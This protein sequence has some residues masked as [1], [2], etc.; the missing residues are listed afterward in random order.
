MNTTSINSKTICKLTTSVIVL[1]FITCK[2]SA[3]LAEPKITFISATTDEDP[4]GKMLHK[5]ISA[6]AKSLNIELNIIQSKA[7]QHTTPEYLS[8]LLDAKPDYLIAASTRLNNH[9][10]T[11]SK[12]KEIYI[13]SSYPPS[14]EHENTLGLPRLQHKH[15]IG[16]IDYN[17]KEASSQLT[18]VMYS[19]YSKQHLAF[20]TQP[21][22]LAFNG[23]K[24]TI[25]AIDRREGLISSANDLNIKINHI[26][27][28]D[29]QPNSSTRSLDLSLKRYPDTSI[30]WAASDAISL[31]IIK[32]LKT[33][34][35]KPNIDF[36]TAGFDWTSEGLDSIERGEMLASAGGQFLYGSWL[37]VLAYDHYHGNDFKPYGI[38]YSI[39][40]PII[41]SSNIS[42][43]R[44]FIDNQEWNNIDFKKF[45]QTHNDNFTGY[46]FNIF[47]EILE[48]DKNL[49]N[50]AI[51]PTAETD[52]SNDN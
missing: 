49:D 1:I 26:F 35:L 41:D 17:H 24:S 44:P 4:F 18:S 48:Q 36:V 9:L 22:L 50:S 46:N 27:D 12:G 15:W 7:N 37:L 11:M 32:K 30:F 39:K 31:N 34:N 43:I 45:T 47:D 38:S 21:S 42:K 19:S 3:C 28:F 33:H 40:M 16:T 10:I 13:L 5:S 29:W 14:K 6:A 8:A 20:K 23:A 2:T 51:M 52:T 25:P